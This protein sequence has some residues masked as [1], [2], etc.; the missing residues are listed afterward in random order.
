MN[1]SLPPVRTHTRYHTMPCECH[2]MWIPCH[3][4]PYYYCLTVLRNKMPRQRFFVWTRDAENAFCCS[5]TYPS[6]HPQSV[7]PH[8][9]IQHDTIRC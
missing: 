1:A 8:H 2:T 5:S 7:I 3:A 4:M 6:T 9:T